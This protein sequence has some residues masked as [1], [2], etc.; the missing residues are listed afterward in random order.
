MRKVIQYAS[1]YTPF[2]FG[3]ST[4]FAQGTAVQEVNRI[5]GIIDL[6]SPVITAL[7]SIATIAAFLYFFLGLVNYIR[8]DKVTVEDAKKQMLWGIVGIFVLVS[9]WG[10]VYL[11]Q[12]AILG[13]KGPSEADIEFRNI[14][15]L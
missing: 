2:A 9:I 4:V 10:L 8:K 1:L 11:L 14:E 6:F 15:S 7:V 3:S 12:T 5:L 13:T